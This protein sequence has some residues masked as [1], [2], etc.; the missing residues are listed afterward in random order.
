VDISESE[1]QLIDDTKKDGDYG[2]KKRTV[3]VAVKLLSRIHKGQKKGGKLIFE[4]PDG[5]KETILIL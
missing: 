2:T 4:N 1:D 5:T 3:M